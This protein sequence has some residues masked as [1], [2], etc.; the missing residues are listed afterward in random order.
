M[1]ALYCVSHRAESRIRLSVHGRRCHGLDIEI[2][3]GRTR[4]LYGFID[5]N[6][7]AWLEC[8]D[9]AVRLRYARFED[10]RCFC[11]PTSRYDSDTGFYCVETRVS[12]NIRRQLC[13]RRRF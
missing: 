3:I 1:V 7:E 2:R 11:H 5:G 8:T 9:T 10:H 12:E 6:A 4:R 13:E